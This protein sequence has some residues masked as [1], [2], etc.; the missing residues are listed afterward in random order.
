MI[1]KKQKMKKKH[2]DGE[3]EL[4]VASRACHAA[5]DKNVELHL[6]FIFIWHRNVLLII[7][8]DFDESFALPKKGLILD[9]DCFAKPVPLCS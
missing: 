1:M 9:K 7:L 4:S 2:W 5:A 8:E 6:N 3:N